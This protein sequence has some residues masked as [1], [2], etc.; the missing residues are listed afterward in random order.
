M[1]EP[2]SLAVF[3][4]NCSSSVL[5]FS[6]PVWACAS[7]LFADS[8]FVWALLKTISA[9][10][11]SSV[12][13][14]IFSFAAAALDSA[15]L[16]LAI[17]FLIS[18]RRLSFLVIKTAAASSVTPSRVRPALP[19]FSVSS[20]SAKS[21]FFRSS[22]RRFSETRIRSLR[23]SIF[24]SAS[25][26]F[27]CRSVD[28]S[29]TTARRSFAVATS[30]G[31]FAAKGCSSEPHTGQDSPSF[32]SARTLVNSSI[33]TK[34]SSSSCLEVSDWISFSY[35]SFL[36]LQ[37][38]SS[39]ESLCIT[40]SWRTISSFWSQTALSADLTASSNGICSE[41]LSCSCVS[42][43]RVFPSRISLKRFSASL[44]NTLSASITEAIFSF[45]ILSASASFSCDLTVSLALSAFPSASANAAERV[46]AVIL[47]SLNSSFRW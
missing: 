45:R 8:N 29:F 46:S 47:Q 27:F 33:W 17:R 26:W 16:A 15:S 35:P 1:T 25:F 2:Y 9:R 10:W 34:A 31:R 40:S 24:L 21:K 4:Q 23:T 11:S 37:L 19:H 36:L 43:S 39:A 38:S 6:L 30:G 5:A 18:I 32:N 20:S 41:K 44:S 14:A 7:K 12:V 13:P 22:F 28:S 42:S 3:R